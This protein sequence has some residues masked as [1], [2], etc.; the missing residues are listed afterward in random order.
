MQAKRFALPAR[1]GLTGL[2]VT[3]LMLM[4]PALG[5]GRAAAANHASAGRDGQ[6]QAGSP[7]LRRGSGYDR[8]SGSR[9][10]RELQRRLRAA[11]YRPGPIDGLYGSMTERALSTFQIHHGLAPDGVAGP[12]TAK[13]LRD[14]RAARP[15]G[16]GAGFGDPASRREVRALQRRLRAAGQ[17]PGPMDG[18]YG[19]LTERA[20]ARFQQDRGLTGD[21]VAGPRTLAALQAPARKPTPSSSPATR[22]SRQLVSRGEVLGLQRGEAHPSV[23]LLALL[24]LGAGLLALASVMLRRRAP[25][26]R[27]SAPAG[28]GRVV[29]LHPR[30]EAGAAPPPARRGMMEVVP[31]LGYVS[32]TSEGENGSDTGV[33]AEAITVA[34]RR[35]GLRLIEVVRDVETESGRSL[36]RPGLSYALER[37]GAGE[38][39]GLVVSKLERLSR[40]VDDLGALVEW[41][42][43]ND[44]RLVAVDLGIDTDTESG[45]LAAKTVVSLGGLG[46][47]TSAGRSRQGLAAV[48]AKEGPSRGGHSGRPAVADRP[49]L[50]RW[51]ASMRAQGM[52][53]Q[54]IADVLNEEDVPTLRGGE[55]WRPS[56]V[57][58]AAGYKRRS[59]KQRGDDERSGWG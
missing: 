32:V 27:A 40:S 12:R 35:L 38:A 30:P 29:E 48:Q 41:F 17:G 51:I 21:G 2:L 28:G 5:P 23:A 47:P 14:P 57:Q 10:V 25:R 22:P 3:A 55:L 18:L 36:D 45:R 13:A 16:R 15:L 43:R 46:R 53:L 49:A 54:A 58:T 31:M 4:A 52:T 34:S 39:Q 19:P 9:Q 37:I 42:M 50:M 56:S 20:V 44:A 24:A 7:Q 26:G 8:V 6:S 33:Q 11:G 1:S 59:R